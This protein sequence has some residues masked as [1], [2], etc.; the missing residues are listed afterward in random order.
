MNKTILTLLT[1]FLLLSLQGTATADAGEDAYNVNCSSCH[2]AKGAAPI[3]PGYPKLNGQ[4]AAYTFKQ[5]KDFQSGAR[6]DPT[7]N[8]LA[9]LAI[10]KEQ[11]IADY[12]AAQ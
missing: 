9:G 12:L 1:S 10:G 2:G 6:K 5:I 11:A 4:D 8:A 3:I 7:M